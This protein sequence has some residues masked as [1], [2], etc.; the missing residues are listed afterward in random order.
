LSELS[1]DI[2][3]AL[4]GSLDRLY[5]LGQQAGAATQQL[6]VFSMQL[7]RMVDAA[8]PKQLPPGVRV[9]E[10][11]DP[12]PSLQP[13]EEKIA[14]CEQLLDDSLQHIDAILSRIVPMGPA[15]EK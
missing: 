1:I 2:P 15:D 14:K 12:P 5:L 13:F 7:N 11:G 4:E 8:K 10:R 6:V 3:P 9:L